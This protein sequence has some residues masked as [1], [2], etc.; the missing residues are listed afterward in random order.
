MQRCLGINPQIW[1]AFSRKIHNF[2][3]C[4]SPLESDL[5]KTLPL[6]KIL[7]HTFLRQMAVRIC[8]YLSQSH[9]QSGDIGSHVG[10]N[11]GAWYE[12]IGGGMEVGC[13]LHFLNRFCNVWSKNFLLVTWKFRG[14]SPPPMKRISFLSKL[15]ALGLLQSV[16]RCHD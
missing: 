9:A 5:T 14:R 15:L 8:E 4:C 12:Y 1:P 6:A 16:T 10:K 2:S 13:H 11:L 3:C 7:A